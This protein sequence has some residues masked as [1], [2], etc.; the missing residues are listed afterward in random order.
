M[1]MTN[2]AGN[3]LRPLSTTPCQAYMDNRLQLHEVIDALLRQTGPAKLMI[4]TFSTSDGFL[5]HIYRLKNEGLI[6]SCVLFLDLKATRK[7]VLLKGFIASVADE[8]HL[9][10]N[11]SKVVLIQNDSHRV[12]IVTSQNQT[13]GNRMECGIITTDNNI[14]NDINNGFDNLR[15]QSVAIGAI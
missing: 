12:T 10:E 9:C 14:F 5:R 3:I 6:T 2:R 4:S 8:V 1:T 11:H 13:T 15:T 7:T